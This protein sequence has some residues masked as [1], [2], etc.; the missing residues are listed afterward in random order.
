VSAI[1]LGGMSLGGAFGPTDQAESFDCLDAAWEAGIDWLD[2]ADIY[3]P[4]V[5]ERV[6]G[7]WLAARGHPVRLATKGAI[8][9]GPP[10]RIDNSAAW[11]R[12]ALEGS[13]RRLGVARVDVYY[14]HR[15][16]PAV[17]IE[18]LAGFMGR[19]IEA[20]TIGGWGLSEVA[21]ATLR[22]AH[23]VTPV[24]AVQSEYSLWTRQ[25]DLGLIRA[26]ADLG[27]AFVAFSP[28]GRSMLTDRPVDPAA[29][30]AADFR[31]GN[32]R[33]MGENHA[34]NL[35]RTDAFRRFARDRGW[36]AAATALAWV[37]DRAPHVIPIPGTRTAAHLRDW[38]GGAAIRLSAEDH[39]EIDRLLPPGFAA[40][41]R[42]SDAQM[43]GIERYC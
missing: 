35:A 24:A 10:R 4:E 23:A 20:G 40:G 13:L 27:V 7:A 16:D 36:T 19:L 3:G 15:R 8:R 6:I 30:D 38:A 28:L 37:L 14:V 41:D 9:P 12:R 43:A 34:A 25:P 26:C 39:A 1:G 17:P 29:L 42:Y 32:P 5:S 21:P 33:F 11:L 22:R 2:T 18:D 31:R